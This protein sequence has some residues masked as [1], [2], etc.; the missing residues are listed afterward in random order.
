M[1][2]ALPLTKATYISR[3]YPDQIQEWTGEQESMLP[4]YFQDGWDW[5]EQGF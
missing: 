2:Q 5:E 3:A 4:V 1:S